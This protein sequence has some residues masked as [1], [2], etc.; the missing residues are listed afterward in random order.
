MVAKA[1]MKFSSD[2]IKTPEEQRFEISTSTESCVNKNSKCHQFS[3]DRH[4]KTNILHY[5]LIHI[6]LFIKVLLKLDEN[7]GSSSFLKI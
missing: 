7:F 1:H 2:R 4:K 5:P 3:A 6:M